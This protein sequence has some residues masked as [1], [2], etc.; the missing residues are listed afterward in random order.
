MIDV[1]SPPDVSAMYRSEESI[2]CDVVDN[3]RAM[4]AVNG[5]RMPGTYGIRSLY[6][7]LL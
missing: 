5:E 4:L 7:C 6:G 1:V 3:Y 2:A